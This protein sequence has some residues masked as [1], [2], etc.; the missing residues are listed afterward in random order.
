MDLRQIHTVMF[1]TSLGRVSMS[2]SKVKV[3]VTGTKTA[4]FG[5]FGGLRA[6]YV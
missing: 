2:R 3:K 1:G 5:I 6:V 4:F